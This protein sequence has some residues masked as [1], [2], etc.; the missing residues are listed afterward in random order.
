MKHTRKVIALL[1]G[2][3][4]LAQLIG[5]YVSHAYIPH[6]V[7]IYNETTGENYTQTR[8][9]IPYGLGPPEDIEPASSVVSIMIALIIAVCLVFLLIRLRAEIVLRYWFFVVVTIGISL[10]LYAFLKSIPAAS[11][12][13]FIVALPL[14]YVKVFKRHIY[15]HNVTELLVY[16]GIAAVFIPLLSIPSVIVLLILISVYDMYAVWQSGFMQKM[17][18]YQI[19]KVRVFPGFFIPYLGKH[20]RAAVKKAKLAG[21]KGKKVQVNLAILGGGDIVFPIIT[22]G[23]VLGAWGFIPALFVTAGATLGL[24]SLF[25]ISQKGKFYPA[26]PFITLGCFVGLALGY[27]VL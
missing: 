15:T 16:P 10:A 8:Y 26:M 21:K 7:P 23:V 20:E 13:A 25:L 2:M 11:L 19:E 5:L 3:F 22:A 9:D 4:L 6:S 18:K 17:A 1:I 12:I 14:A 27:L 24:L